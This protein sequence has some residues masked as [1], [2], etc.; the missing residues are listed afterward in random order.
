MKKKEI[1]KLLEI[2]NEL[3]S[4]YGNDRVSRAEK[5]EK[6]FADGRAILEEAR[7]KMKPL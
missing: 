6:L 7:D 5:M 1:Y 2:L 4:T 3:Q